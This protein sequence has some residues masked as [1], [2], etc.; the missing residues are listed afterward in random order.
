MPF[1]VGVV[2]QHGDDHLGSRRFSTAP[3]TYERRKVCYTGVLPSQG[4]PILLLVDR[5][6]CLPLSSLVAPF[7]LHTDNGC[8]KDLSCVFE[9]LVIVLAAHID[10]S[11]T[12]AK[13]NSLQSA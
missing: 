12:C 4:L 5:I 8:C 10:A 2:L 13:L 3:C 1:L 9:V 11:T 6:L 7:P